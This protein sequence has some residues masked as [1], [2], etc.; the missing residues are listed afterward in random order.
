MPSTVTSDE[1]LVEA[2]SK[3]SLISGLVGFAA[4]VPGGLFLRFGGS[5]WVLGL[6]P[7]VV[8]RGRSWSAGRSPRRRSPTT[9]ETAEAKEELRGVGVL[10]AASAM[11][12]L[13]GVVGFLTFLLAFALRTDGSPTWHFGV[14]LGALGRRAR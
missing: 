8:R 13:R 12:L 1:E 5:E 9:P 3:L 2:N 4:A 7:V 6:A 10:L 11:G 14:V